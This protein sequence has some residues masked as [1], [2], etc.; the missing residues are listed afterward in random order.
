MLIKFI[1]LTSAQ[2]V[3]MP[4]QLK[5]FPTETNSSLQVFDPELKG[6]MTSF[7]T[8]APAIDLVKEFDPVVGQK[9]LPRLCWVA[10][11]HEHHPYL[12]K[13]ISFDGHL[14]APLKHHVP[15]RTQRDGKWFLDEG[16]CNI[17]G[18]LDAKLTRS[19][20]V[21]HG[22]GILD[23]LDHRQPHPAIKYG[24]ARGHKT[25]NHLLLSLEVSR[26]TFIHRLAYLAY[27][28]SLRYKWGQELVD[29]LWWKEFTVGCGQAW[30][31]SVW[32]VIYRQW[33]TRN[34]VGV[35]VKPLGTYDY[36]WYRMALWFGVPIWVLFPE[37]GCYRDT[38]RRMGGTVM[39]EWEPTYRQVE[40][41]RAAEKARLAC[42]PAESTLIPSHLQPHTDPPLQS[43]QDHPLA[44]PSDNSSV[45]HSEPPFPPTKVPRGAKWHASWEKFFQ[46]R[47][48]KDRR[49]CEAASPATASSWR[50]RKKYAKQFH[51]PKKAKVYEWEACDSG[52]FFRILVTHAEVAES[53]EFYFKPALIYNEIADTWDHCRFKYEA[54]VEDGPPDDLNDDDDYVMRPW[55]T[56]PEQPAAPPHDNSPPGRFLSNR[57][58]FIPISPTTPPGTYIS[59]GESAACRIVGLDTDHPS[60]PTKHLVSFV[61]SIYTGKLP[62]DQCD[63]SPTSP[64]DATFSDFS[65]KLIQETIFSSSI[66]EL[67]EEL[68]FT[69]INPLSDSQLLVMHESLSVL[70]TVRAGT[71][72]QLGAMLEYL[73]HNGSRF[74]LLYTQLQPP[75]PPHFN[76]LQFP[77][78]D[79]SWTPGLE[80]FQVYMSRLKIFF[81][82]R[83]YMAAASFSRGGIAWRIAREVLGIEGSTEALL[84]TL[85]D[86]GSPV[87]TSRGKFWFH[88]PQEG[89]WFYLVGGYETFTGSWFFCFYRVD[90]TIL[91]LKQER[92]IRHETF[93]GGLRLQPG[94]AAVL[95]LG[96]GPRCASAGS[97]NA[98]KEFGSQEKLHTPH[99]RGK[100]ASRTKEA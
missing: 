21:V 16:T 32:D 48:E 19:I 91:T 60:N 94:K 9:M 55:Y 73:L 70:Q 84:K 87:H 77:T 24:F 11:G 6:I 4:T 14:L 98:W 66:P 88:E 71:Q 29:Q 8:H 1:P 68:L 5:Q 38:D 56:E 50:D 27:L 22:D 51:A 76:I 18:S 81:L 75:A 57:Y 99:Q 23:S 92:V 95:M 82:E 43:Q 41:S 17:W 72:L 25:E 61:G 31:D 58:G 13:S 15:K 80:D 10:P 79:K 100:K 2:Q 37:E 34:F 39:K 46:D 74:T 36:R 67:S 12:P 64:S 86:Q 54:A 52:G 83:P 44:G 28:I 93:H 26:H 40:A 7:E 90:H 49:L 97:K 59:F 42:L 89:E 78:H 30:V 96:V 45:S 62:S 20:T 63:L 47:D 33:S 85:P 53:W 3:H 35:V 69:F 65:R